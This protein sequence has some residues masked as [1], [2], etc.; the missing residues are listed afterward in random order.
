MPEASSLFDELTTS[1]IQKVKKT[2]IPYIVHTE[3]RQHGHTFGTRFSNSIKSVLSLG[4]DGLIVIGNDTPHLTEVQLKTAYENLLEDKTTIGPSADGGFYLLGI[5]KTA[6]QEIEGSTTSKNA[7][8]SLPWNKE[9]LYSSLVALIASCNREITA[10][11]NLIDIDTIADGIKILG[12]EECL[13]D[14]IFILLSDLVNIVYLKAT[15]REVSYVFLKPGTSHN[16][17]SPEPKFTY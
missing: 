6:F 5:S 4:Y 17:G 7:F 13:E 1:T 10:L 15:F 3:A 11:K 8:L 9:S 2:G 14:T 12:K 16:K